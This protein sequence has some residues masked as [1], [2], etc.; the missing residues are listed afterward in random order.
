[1][2]FFWPPLRHASVSLESL[3]G[4]TARC[5][6]RFLCVPG[7]VRIHVLDDT[8]I[9]ACHQLPKYLS[10]NLRL[11]EAQ[12]G[13]D[14]ASP[15]SRADVQSGHNDGPASSQEADDEA[16]EEA[17]RPVGWEI[18][19]GPQA[20]MTRA[21]LWCGWVMRQPIDWCFGEELDTRRPELRSEMWTSRRSVDAWWWA[22]ECSSMTRA[23]EKPLPGGGPPP[24]RSMEWPDGLPDLRPEDQERVDMDN[25]NSDWAMG[26]AVETHEVG[27]ANVFENPRN[28][29]LWER[30]STKRTFKAIDA[31]YSDYDACCHEGARRNASD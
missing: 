4:M 17:R 25:E 20:I 23:R 14:V 29:Y 27:A 8:W 1:M 21:L 3:S 28:A 5:P 24:L 2:Q 9:P 11:D 7:R 15:A 18:M 10:D 30:K 19:S 13:R 22:L 31:V 16:E 12:E 26:M 6:F